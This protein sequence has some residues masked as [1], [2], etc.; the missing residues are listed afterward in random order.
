MQTTLSLSQLLMW[1]VCLTDLSGPP[2]NGRVQP[3]TVRTAHTR[4]LWTESVSRLE[5]TPENKQQPHQPVS[6]C[7]MSLFY[8]FAHISTHTHTHTYLIPVCSV[9]MK[10]H[11]RL[12]I[13]HFIINLSSV[14]VMIELLKKHG[15]SGQRL[16]FCFIQ[17]TS[18]IYQPKETEDDSCHVFSDLCVYMSLHY[19]YMLQYLVEQILYFIS[20]RSCHPCIIKRETEE[21]KCDQ[22]SLHTVCL[23]HNDFIYTY[24]ICFE[25][26]S[27]CIEW[28]ISLFKYS[29][30]CFWQKAAENI[31]YT[32]QYL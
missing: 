2:R 25:F 10:L 8:S 6:H 4:H 21:G 15:T 32:L 19:V 29:W 26:E 3:T 31:Y 23:K 12:Q 9:H 11:Q 5:R 18:Q 28:S 22:Y 17:L 20:E 24:L 13:T 1:K 7:K 30:L 14:T 16:P 27:L